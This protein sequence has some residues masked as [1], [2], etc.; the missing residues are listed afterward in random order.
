M[1]HKSSSDAF[2]AIMESHLGMCGHNKSVQIS[3]RSMFP[4][5]GQGLRSFTTRCTGALTFSV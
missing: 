1:A 5:N 2:A 3:L 4:L